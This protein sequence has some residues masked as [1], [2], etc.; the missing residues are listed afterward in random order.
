MKSIAEAVEDFKTLSTALKAKLEQFLAPFAEVLPDARYRRSLLQFVPGMLA[1]RSPQPAKAAA[2]APDRS[3]QK[4]ALAKSFYNL[5]RTPRFSHQVWLEP[6]YADARQAVAQGKGQRVLVALDPVYLEKPYARKQ[7][8]LSIIL[9]N[10]PPG[11]LPEGKARKTRGYPALFGL[12]LNGAWPAV[13]YHRLFSYTT[14][15]FVSQPWEWMQAFKA[16][17]RNLP[18]HRVCVVADAEADD[19]KLWRAAREEGLDF[20]FRATKERNIEVWNPLAHRW[21][22]EE[23]QSLARVMA[24]REQFKTEFHHAGKAIPAQ[25]RLD[26]FR[27]RLPQKRGQHYQAVV[28][29]T[30][31]LV[32]VGPEEEK[33]LPPRHL[34]MVTPRPVRGRRAARQVYTDWCSRGRIESF[35]RFLQEEGVG[36]EGFLVRKLERIRRIVI[37]VVVAAL[38]VLRL[39]SLWDPVLVHWLRRLGS[40]LGDTRLDRGGAY[41]LLRAVRRI[42]DA[43]SLL[44]W[45]AKVP[46][47]LEGLPGAT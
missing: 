26:W 6:L 45:M 2:Y 21:E 11:S 17:R 10:R 5:V 19:Q 44:D 18:Q 9:K 28:A 39:A 41:L 30:R 37:L 15:D 43:D 24:G 40:D 7:E 34:V 32:K 33:W 42:L 12:V 27:F 14:A 46:P 29:E 25:V 20:I 47:P 4:R 31:I 36:V 23:L 13:V 22:K 16:I 1:A 35:Y 3:T 8:G 38:F